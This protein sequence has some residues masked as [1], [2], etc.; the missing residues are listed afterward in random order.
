MLILDLIRR[1]KDTSHFETKRRRKDGTQIEVSISISPV[2]RQDNQIIGAAKIFRDITDRKRAEE[3]TR[4]AEKIEVANRLA[5]SVAHEVNNPLSA[6]TNLLYLLRGEAL[7]DRALELL[8]MA[9][10]ELARVAHITA[11]ALGF[12]KEIGSPSPHQIS[13]IMDEAIALHSHRIE[14]GCIQLEKIYEDPTMIA[15]HRG[16]I[17]QVLVNLIGN[18]L[19]AMNGAGRLLIRVRANRMSSEERSGVRVLIADSGSGIA[20]ELLERLFEPFST[21]KGQT[22]T[23]LGLWMCQQIIA[24]HRGHI[25]IKSSQIFNRHGTVVRIS[26]PA[27]Q[28]SDDGRRRSGL[29]EM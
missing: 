27:S 21:T 9:E 4:R 20:E 8:S 13:G 14:A 15:C 11:Q 2:R 19:D 16:E 5:T 3:L 1:G 23:G 12:Y 28:T 25:S 26:L 24:R 6:V 17:R 29:S 22:R 10:R 18:S 7:N